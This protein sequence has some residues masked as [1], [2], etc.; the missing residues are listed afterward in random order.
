MA[1]LVYK[2][3]NLFYICICPE[4]CPERCMRPPT[5]FK[6]INS[7]TCLTLFHQTMPKARQPPLRRPRLLRP[8][9]TLQA[10]QPTHVCKERRPHP[11]LAQRVRPSC[12]RNQ[13]RPA[14]N[15]FGMVVSEV[16]V[17]VHCIVVNV[18]WYE[19]YLLNS[20]AEPVSLVLK[21]RNRICNCLWYRRV[22]LTAQQ[23][24]FPLCWKTRNK[25]CS[26]V[27]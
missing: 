11:A 12:R 1:A 19:I 14:R 18:P 7:H 16:V 26:W 27:I 23:S 25:L 21:V 3:P 6:T 22:F 2:Y 15:L 17:T 20:T 5:R 9:S 24:L 10:R 8:L 13:S 4:H